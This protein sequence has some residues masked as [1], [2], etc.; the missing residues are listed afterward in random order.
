[1]RMALPV[2]TALRGKA[3]TPP[4]AAPQTQRRAPLQTRVES[5][6]EAASRLRAPADPAADEA[7][8]AQ[9]TWG[10]TGCQ[11]PAPAGAGAAQ[12]CRRT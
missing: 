11:A 6:P 3:R 1:M 9:A 10:S 8:P 5:A 7:D 2:K 4:M 12:Q